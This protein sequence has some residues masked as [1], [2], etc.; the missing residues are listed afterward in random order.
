MRLGLS[1]AAAPD[2][3]LADLAAACMRRGLV[4]LELVEDHGHGISA[5]DVERLADHR[6]A[7]IGI[8]PIEIVGYVTAA[9]TVGHSALAA[10]SM[11]LDAPMVIATSGILS[12]LGT[13][14]E[15]VSRGG[16]AV[17]RL[18]DDE[19]MRYSGDCASAAVP[20]E[21]DVNP[22]VRP[23]H[24]D[25]LDEM[26]R[27]EVDVRSV[28]IRGGG[29]ESETYEGRGVD[30]LLQRLALESWSGTLILAPGSTRYGVAWQN[31][32]G[33]RGGWGCGSAG[34]SSRVQLPIAG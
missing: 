4:A 33:R 3:G 9:T 30:K 2:A 17:V 13:A 6:K 25:V 28:H 20:V 34:E 5:T 8:Y 23:V 7:A 21:W 26:E 12:R 1:S 14:L 32:L 15:I 24:M 31:W 10:L 19:P 27:H 18:F 16:T 29:P 11:A 22:A